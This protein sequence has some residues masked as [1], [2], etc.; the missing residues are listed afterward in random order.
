MEGQDDY[1]HITPVHLPLGTMVVMRYTYDN[2]SA[3]IRNPYNPPQ[4]VRFGPRSTDEMAELMLQIVPSDAAALD[5]LRRD[6]SAKLQRDVIAGL[7]ALLT[8]NPADYLSHTEL[9]VQY[10]EAGELE[11]GIAHLE[12]AIAVKA[13]FADAHY[14]LGS[15]ATSPEAELRDPAEAVLFAERAAKRTGHQDVM[16][17][18]SLAA[19]YAGVGRFE[20]A[21]RA[22]QSAIELASRANAPHTAAAIRQRLQ[23]YLQYKPFRVPSP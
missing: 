21:V 20:Q 18:D 23:L 10:V 12:E 4:R 3:N 8:E 14:N 15:A 13:D 7:Q 2:S 1:R 6:V 16:V 9:A 17:L 11:R 19:A 22:A 5:E